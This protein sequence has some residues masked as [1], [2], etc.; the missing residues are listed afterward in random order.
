V[1][2][3]GQIRDRLVFADEVELDA[4]GV[5]VRDDAGRTIQQV[6]DPAGRLDERGVAHLGVREDGNA[7]TWSGGLSRSISPK[8]GAEAGS[9]M[10]V[11]SNAVSAP[12]ARQK[13]RVRFRLVT[14]AAAV[15]ER[16]RKNFAA[17]FAGRK[18]C[19]Q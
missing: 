19:R 1:A 13:I 7:E 11:G 18:M 17:G 2:I 3:L 12:T 15:F 4:K 8:A 14:L 6:I 5:E 9:A 10:A 16:I